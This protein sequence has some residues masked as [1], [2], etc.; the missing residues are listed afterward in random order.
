M[1]SLLA[2]GVTALALLASAPVMAQDA[3][4]T[5]DAP[6]YRQLDFW[7]G[8]WDVTWVDGDTGEI[9]AGTNVITRTL[10]G[11]VIEERFDGGD[12]VPLRGMS[13]STYHRQKEEWRQLWLDNTGAY[14]PFAGGPVRDRFILTLDRPADEADAAYRRMVWEN[15]GPDSLDWRWQSSADEGATW[16]DLWH[17]RYVRQDD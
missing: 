3:A 11:C 15:I 14:L 2:G 12:S 1:R 10:D 9:G 16:S 17:I 4:P 7:V 6:E 8:E 13:V 5:C